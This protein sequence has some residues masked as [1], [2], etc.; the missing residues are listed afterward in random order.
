MDLTDPSTGITPASLAEI[1]DYVP[2]PNYGRVHHWIA[3]TVFR[4]DFRVLEPDKESVIADEEHLIVIVGEALGVVGL[5]AIKMLC[6]RCHLLRDNIH[7]EHGGVAAYLADME[8]KLCGG[9]T[10]PHGLSCVAAC[11]LPF[12]LL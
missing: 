4:A 7:L 2:T 6:W 1:V 10:A 11:M 8:V 12:H 5:V 9:C 3:T